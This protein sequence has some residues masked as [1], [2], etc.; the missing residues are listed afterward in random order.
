MSQSAKGGR[1]KKSGVNPEV[2]AKL[3]HFVERDLELTEKEAVDRLLG[4]FVN[5]V[6]GGA[7]KKDDDRGC[8]V[9]GGQQNTYFLFIGRLLQAL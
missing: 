1:L 5:E 3:S 2:A 8:F 7:F 9:R 4:R 6:K